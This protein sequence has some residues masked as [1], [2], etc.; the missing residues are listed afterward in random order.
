MHGIG[1]QSSTMLKRDVAGWGFAFVLT[2]AVASPA[3]AGKIEFLVAEPPWLV[4]N[5]DSYVVAIDESRSDLIAH[6]RALADWVAAGGDQA[7]SPGATIVVAPVAPG[8][9]G[10]NRNVLA[11]G[12]PLWSWHVAGDPSFTDFTIEVLDGWPTFVEED[13]PGWIANTNGHIGFWNYTV[14]AELGQ[15]VPEPSSLGL[16]VVATVVLSIGLAGGRRMAR[17]AT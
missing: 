5:E 6:A 7:N 8:A 13:V 9:D 16:A 11:P 2:A 10:I 12:E 15:L 17:V 4:H 3:R 14:V 1:R